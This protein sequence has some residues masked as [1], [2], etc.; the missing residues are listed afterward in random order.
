MIIT[1]I[2]Y[3]LVN[4]DGLSAY[5]GEGSGQFWISGLNCEDSDETIFSCARSDLKES[6]CSKDAVVLCDREL[7]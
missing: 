4:N 3:V 1:L 2:F 6:D 7:L 5:Y